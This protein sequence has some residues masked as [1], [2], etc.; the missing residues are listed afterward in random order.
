M[1]LAGMSKKGDENFST[2]RE[3]VIAMHAQVERVI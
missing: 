3:K 1:Y 2:L